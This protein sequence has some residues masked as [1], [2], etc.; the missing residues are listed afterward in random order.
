MKKLRPDSMGA[1]LSG[2][3]YFGTAGL[4]FPAPFTEN[5][6]SV[7]EFDR[8][9]FGFLIIMYLVTKVVNYYH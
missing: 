1:A 5:T 3:G 8:F 7:C 4:V 2:G 9:V 6:R